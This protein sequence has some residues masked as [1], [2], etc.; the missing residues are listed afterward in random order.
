MSLSY[1]ILKGELV[2]KIKKISSPPI[3]NDTSPIPPPPVI[4]EESKDWRKYIPPFITDN[5]YNRGYIF[6]LINLLKWLLLLIFFLFLMKQCR[7]CTNNQ[8]ILPVPDNNCK[9]KVDSLVL[10]N[11]SL[12]KQLLIVENEKQIIDSLQTETENR[13]KRK[14][15]TIGQIT[16]TLIWNSLDDLDLALEDPQGEILWFRNDIN[17]N[18]I[19]F[20]DID[21]NSSDD[22]TSNTPIENIY[23]NKPIDGKYRI[24]VNWYSRN[25]DLTQIPYYLELRI[26]N[27]ILKFKNSIY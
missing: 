18:T 19:G 25:T 2:G 15:G 14:N 27:E 5:N 1:G 8:N 17:S 24:L 13:R 20:L 26:G 6:H 21:A 12:R 7:S 23:I 3:P 9:N 4:N 11:D 16:A 10:V 22:N